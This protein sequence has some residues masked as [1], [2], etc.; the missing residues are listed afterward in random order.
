MIKINGEIIDQNH[1]PDNS[2]LVKYQSDVGI[3]EIEWK[4]ESDA[5]IF[6]LYCLKRHL[7]NH[8]MHPKTYLK[9]HYIPHARQ[10]RVKKEEDVFT[11]KYFAEILNSLNF[12]NVEVLDPH[13]SVSKALINNISEAPFLALRQVLEGIEEEYTDYV[14]CYPDDGACKKYSDFITLPYCYGRK[15]RDWT[16]GK[17]L[18][19]DIITNGI[20]LKDKT[21]LIIDDIISY[22]GSMY[23]TAKKLKELGCGDIFIYASHVENSILKGDLIKSGLFKKIYTTNSLFTEKHDLIQVL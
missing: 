12:D 11:L 5:E 10:D 21:I 7:D 2:L 13:S 23:Y 3:N 19:L 18:G 1:F 8:W 17:I 15:N 4:Y 20:D 6:T 22:G 14:V 16:N 9:M